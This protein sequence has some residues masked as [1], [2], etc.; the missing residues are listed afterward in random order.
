V[1]DLAPTDCAVTRELNSI[2]KTALLEGMKM[3]KDR[4]NKCI[5]QGGMYFEE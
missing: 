4:A 1:L 2:S 3:L 5:D